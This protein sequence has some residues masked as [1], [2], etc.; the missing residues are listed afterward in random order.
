MINY[1][2][3]N[4]FKKIYYGLKGRT[5]SVSDKLRFL[6]MARSSCIYD[7]FKANFN[8]DL[9]YRYCWL[10]MGHESTLAEWDNVTDVING[11]ESKAELWYDQKEQCIEYEGY[12]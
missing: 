3:L 1:K 11:G 9:S 10:D 8:K 12:V 2:K 4:S 5:K 7:E 6:Q